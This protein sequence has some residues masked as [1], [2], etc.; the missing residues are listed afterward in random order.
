MAKNTSSQSL[1]KQQ[2]AARICTRRAYEPPGSADGRRV[3]V[4][5]LWPRGVSRE[6]LRIDE[7]RR[8]VAPSAGLRKWFGHDPD[9]WEGFCERYFA[10]LDEKP[11]AWRPMLAAARA[12]RVTFVFGARDEVHNNAVA[13]RVYLLRKLG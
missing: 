1:N 5:A 6:T 4:D 8:E 10:E 13:L 7:W 9:K 3:L 11:G 2:A 12:G